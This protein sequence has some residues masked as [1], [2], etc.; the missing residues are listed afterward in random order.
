ME[1][2]TNETTEQVQADSYEQPKVT[3]YGTLLELTQ[4]NGTVTP[5]DVPMGQPNSAFPLS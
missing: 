5:T 2:I 4:V 3:D 1:R